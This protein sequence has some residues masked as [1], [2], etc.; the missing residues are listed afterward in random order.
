MRPA[1]A[2]PTYRL[3]VVNADGTG[4]MQLTRGNATS[5]D[6]RADW[7]PDAS[8]LVFTR[9]VKDRSCWIFSMKADGSGLRRLTPYKPPLCR[10]PNVVG[11]PLSKASHALR[12]GSCSRGRVR[13]KH[14]REVGSGRVSW[15]SPK[16]GM[17][18]P[19]GSAVRLVVSLGR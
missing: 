4:F 12:A 13:R 14:S 18:G 3:F 9:C 2:W 19:V 17:R 11:K 8:K 10:V 5:S 7:S 15:Q 16:P 6:S 1:A